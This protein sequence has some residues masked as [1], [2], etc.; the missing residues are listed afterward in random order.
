M[1]NFPHH[2]IV[3]AVGETVGPVTVSSPNLPNLVTNAPAEFDGPGDLWSPETML[4][5]AVANCFLLTFRAVARASKLEWI[6]LTCRAQGVLERIER[7]TQFTKIE[8]EAKLAVASGTD[9]EKALRLLE[10][11]EQGCL[12]TNSLKA[13]VV[14]KAEVE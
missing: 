10:K 12:I 6:S 13:H 7:M 9:K 2:Y 4:V 5:G 8:L 14:L 3:T 1:Q 11:A